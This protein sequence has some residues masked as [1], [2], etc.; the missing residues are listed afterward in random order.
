MDACHVHAISFSG[1]LHFNKNS[2]TECVLC[3]SACPGEALSIKGYSL[4]RTLSDLNKAENPVL[5]CSHKDGLLSHTGGPCHGFLSKVYLLAFSAILDKSIQLNMTQCS[6]C[7]NV[8]IIDK[9]INKFSDL[10]DVALILSSDDLDYQ[11]IQ[12]SRRDF[13]RLLRGESIRTFHEFK[14][15]SKEGE[16]QNCYSVK[17]LPHR[18]KILNRAYK[19]CSD[20]IRLRLEGCYA[21]MTTDASCNGCMACTAMCP[22]GALS[23]QNGK[24]SFD[25][26]SCTSCML[27]EEFCPTQAIKIRQGPNHPVEDEAQTFQ[28]ASFP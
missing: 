16:S 1:G 28:V 12:T 8:H 17:T 2:C 26:F 18:L 4:Q 20:A 9:L 7:I 19:K 23:K 10:N 6:D 15:F 25:T 14:D 11:D 3:V 5:A 24:L 22:T 13:F 27:C 21:H